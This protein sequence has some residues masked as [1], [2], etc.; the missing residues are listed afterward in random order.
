MATIYANVI[1]IELL[2]SHRGPRHV[3]RIRCVPATSYTASSDVFQLGAGGKL[4]GVTTALDLEDQIESIRKDGKTVN[5]IGGMPGGA[6]GGASN[7]AHYIDTCAVSGNNLTAELA[8]A[9]ST[10]TDLTV[11]NSTSPMEVW[12]VYD[13][14]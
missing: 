8:V 12:V 6:G 9:D 2:D 7:A 10:E 14:S 1:G 3:A 5:L 4:F 13:L 11:A